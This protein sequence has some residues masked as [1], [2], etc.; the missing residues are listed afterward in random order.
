[1]SVQERRARELAQRRNQI[2]A[3][4]REL[5]ESEGWGAVTTRRLAERIEYS[6]PVLYKHFKD[7]VDIVRTVALEGFGELAQSMREARLATTSPP[8][9]L[10]ALARTYV[11]FAEAN[12]MLYE[13]MFIT[14]ID[15]AF[16]Q[17]DSPPTLVESFDE[18]CRSVSCLAN[19]RALE[20]VAE[21]VWG[22]LH[23]L[24]V[25]DRGGRLRLS[26]RDERIE[27]LVEQLLRSIDSQA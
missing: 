14:P 4:A 7:K 1:M 27:L 22:S 6:Q 11:G 15:L 3:A 20:T 9:A 19:G 5:A 23:G 18:L 26:H 10:R 2:I 21:V 13:A 24:V 12:P 16:G 17:S 8:E 25:L